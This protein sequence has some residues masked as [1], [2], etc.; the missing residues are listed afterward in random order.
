MKAIIGLVMLGCAVNV[1]GSEPSIN[2]SQAKKIPEVALKRILLLTVMDSACTL[3]QSQSGK[4]M[5]TVNECKIVS[6]AYSS[7]CLDKEVCEPVDS[8]IKLYI[9][10]VKPSPSSQ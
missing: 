3:Q 4:G 9:Q 2:A 8:Q 5:D 6:E 7:E 10:S 1:Q